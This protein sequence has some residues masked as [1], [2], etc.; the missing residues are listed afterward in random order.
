MGLV[1]REEYDVL[2]E[3]L[4]R[5]LSSLIDSSTGQSPI[6]SVPSA[7]ELF[8]VSAPDVLPDLFV[9][10]KPHTHLMKT[11]QHPKG[12]LK[13]NPD[14]VR[15]SGHSDFGFITV[16]GPN[17]RSAGNIGEVQMLDL[18]PTFLTLLNEP[19][20]PEMKGRPADQLLTS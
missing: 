2:I 10:W 14:P 11:V 7:A 6:H 9:R 18:A 15:D 12:E 20:P 1:T 8:G 13:Q 4:Q 3:E 5:E 19:V 17:I 16:M